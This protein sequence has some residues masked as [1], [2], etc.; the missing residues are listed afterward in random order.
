M[1]EVRIVME[2]DRA[3]NDGRHAAEDD[4]MDL[5]VSHFATAARLAGSD[6]RLQGLHD[7]AREEGRRAAQSKEIRDGADELFAL[8]E[9]LR[10]ALLGFGGDPVTAC[11][12]V[13]AALAKFSVPRERQWL[14]R[15][16]MPLLDPARWVHLRDEVNELLFLWLVALEHTR[17]GDRAT[18]RQAVAICDAALAFATPAGPW[19]AL[20]ARDRALLE[21]KPPPVPPLAPSGREDSARGCFQ[22]ALLCKLDGRSDATI[23]WL[24]RATELEPSNYWSEF[25]LGFT[26]ERAGHSQRALE[27]YQAA[28]ALRENSPWAWYNRALLRHARGDWDQSLA[29]LNRALALASAQGFDFLEARL[30]LGVVKQVLGDTA[31]ARAAYES[32]VAAAGRGPL[33]RAGRLNRAKLDIESGAVQQAWAE[34]DALLAEDP[35]DF[36]TRFSHALLALELGQ[37]ARAE[38]DLTLLLRDDPGNAAE[39]LPRR[40]LARL[41]LDRPLDAEADAASAFR[42]KPSP[43]IERLWIRTLVALGR[44]DELLWLKTPD[45]LDVLPGGGPALRAELRKAAERLGARV[46]GKA[47]AQAQG[48]APP[49]ALVHRTRAVFLSA[50]GDLAAEAEASRAVALAPGS[51]DAYVVRARVRRRRGDLEGARADLEAGLALE[52]GEPRLFELSARIES[53]TGHPAAALILLN[54]AVTRG[55]GATVH[56]PKAAALMALGRGGEALEEWSL[57]LEEDPEDPRLYLGR[58]RALIGLRRWD[59]ALADLE[60]AADWAVGNPGILFRISLASTVCLPALPARIPHWLAHVRRAWAA[61][62]LTP[63]RGG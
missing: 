36:A 31:G 63:N 46:D 26:H 59:R 2:Y 19:Q 32:V 47:Q 38:A 18:A 43:N 57:A 21:G 22:L 28:V 5:A 61:C 15:P 11:R 30:E 17:P 62:L 60:Q 56:V 52:P 10:F 20:A 27:H 16:P 37:A 35:N 41:A 34:Y 50:L 33:A 58:A 49:P 42:R 3:I 51:V 24:E 1:S 53:E 48:S 25:Y 7:K 12:Q 23:A 13:E 8:G 44:V 55:A 4:D 14:A 6:S 39:Y 40:A 45:D 54:R 9:R 29:D